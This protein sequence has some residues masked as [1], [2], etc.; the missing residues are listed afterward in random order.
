[1]SNVYFWACMVI[2]SLVTIFT[3][4]FF[5][6][7]G[8][9]FK[10]S[11]TLRNLIQYAPSGALIA[12]VIPE[13]FFEKDIVTKTYQFSL[14]PAQLFASVTTIMVYYT[15]KSMLISLAIGMLILIFITTYII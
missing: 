3:R 2:L 10:L 11:P 15:T 13:L 14:H 5:L 12:I 1:M 9:N 7:I 6:T 8:S 4:S